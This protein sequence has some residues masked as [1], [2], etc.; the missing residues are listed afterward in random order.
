MYRRLEVQSERL[1]DLGLT[2]RSTYSTML[3]RLVGTQPV[4]PLK[5]LA[6]VVEP[7]KFYARGDPRPYTTETPL[8]RLVD[9]AR[10]ESDLARRFRNS[11]DEFLQKAPKLG[12]SEDVRSLLAKWRENDM[13]LGPILDRSEQVS[14]AIPLSK[15]LSSLGQLGLEAL[16]FLSSAKAPVQRWQ[17]DARELLERAQKPRAEVEIAII[18]AIRKLVL[19]AGQQEKLK[20]L[21]PEE[22]NSQLDAQV[23]AAKPK[24]QE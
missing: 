15:D 11:V 10:P 3:Q 9:A 14:E 24:R 4:E 21:S 12:K 18:P 2:H 17:E 13:T 8:D 20:T 19:A 22:W 6:D 16:D 7:V 23:E 5:V 1:E